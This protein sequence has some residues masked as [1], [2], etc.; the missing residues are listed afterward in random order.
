MT[1]WG[2]GV[3]DTHTQQLIHTVIMLKRDLM[4]VFFCLFEDHISNYDHK[5]FKRC[6]FLQNKGHKQSV[7]SLKVI[8]KYTSNGGA[9]PGSTIGCVIR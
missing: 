2:G 4:C 8:K 1:M 3:Q 6:I 7:D 5:W 9:E